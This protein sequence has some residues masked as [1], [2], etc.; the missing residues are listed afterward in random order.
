MA[1]SKTSL[2][3]GDLIREILL[4]STEVS[5]RCNKIFPVAVDNAVLPYI[6]YRR[7]SLEQN[8]NKAGQ[9]GADSVSIEVI[10][11]T[12]DYD[13]GVELAEAVRDALDNK[14]D[15][16]DDDETLVMRSCTL[17][18]SEEAWQDDAYVQ[19]LVFNVKI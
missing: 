17:V 11:F 16:Q 13:D 3:A 7:V 2:H 14:R 6:L 12:A 9:P 10:C 4:D 15:I 1:A 8:A 18:D 5:A 19:Q